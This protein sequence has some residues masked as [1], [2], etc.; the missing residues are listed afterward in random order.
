MNTDH[1]YLY[2]LC[3]VVLVDKPCPYSKVFQ[4]QTWLNEKIF[5]YHHKTYIP[6]PLDLNTYFLRGSNE[7]TRDGSFSTI[8]ALL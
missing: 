3:L 2:D 7:N 8:F 6:Y 5:P 1:Y 4:Y